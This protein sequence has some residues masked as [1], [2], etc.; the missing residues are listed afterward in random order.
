MS[1]RAPRLLLP[2]LLWLQLWHVLDFLLFMP[3]EPMIRQQ[4]GLSIEDISLL[5]AVYHVAAGVVGFLL[6][7]R[8]DRFDRK[9]VLLLSLALMLAG[10]ALTGW[11]PS[12][13]WLWASR[14]L[15]GVGGSLLTSMI[16]VLLGD[17]FPPERRATATGIVMAAFPLGAVVGIPLGLVLANSLGWQTVY[18]GLAVG[19]LLPLV[20]SVVFLPSFTQHRNP[21]LP[22]KPWV[23]TYISVWRQ[24]RVR[25]ALLVLAL[26]FVAQSL[27]YTHFSLYLRFNLGISERG[28]DYRT[29]FL[30]IGLSSMF[31]SPLIGR[32]S[33][34]WSSRKVLLALALFSMV[35]VWVYTHLTPASLAT[36]VV[37]TSLLY[38]VNS[39]R[40]VP[41]VT[42]VN[43]AAPSHLRG[44]VLS[45]KI[46]LQNLAQALGASLA[47]QIVLQDGF[48]TLSGYGLAGNLAVLVTVAAI[49]MLVGPLGERRAATCPDS[50]TV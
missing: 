46:T 33:D 15:C 36:V 43:E 50:T 37:V 40:L 20:L 35:P 44:G 27:V 19:G 47:G 7:A 26:L 22:Q 48:S 11:A 42:L 10:Q 18:T 29:V 28:A 21:E 9:H 30:V 45:L 17:A 13:E 32:L 1:T 14:A 25:W 12:L 41:A 4:S 5:V 6:A 38:L 23:S 2:L 31:A 16:L 3:L 39:G 34:K 49:W 24:T 8:I